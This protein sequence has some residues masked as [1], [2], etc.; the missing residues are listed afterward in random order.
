M[1]SNLKKLIGSGFLSGY[2][3]KAPGTFGSFIALLIY[4]IPGFENPII[5]ISSILFSILIGIP[6]GNYFEEIYGKDPGKFT[7]D[8]FIG[9][10]I[11]LLFI[12]KNIIIIF[13][14]FILWRFLDIIKPFPANK[15]ENLSG[16]LGI[17]LDDVISGMYSLI[18]IHIFIVIFF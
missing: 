12:P 7:L 14:S 15:A 10:W 6:L 3:P 16:G 9:T 2:L 8:E 18:I 17:I 1:I 5:I 4:F 13:F 11:S